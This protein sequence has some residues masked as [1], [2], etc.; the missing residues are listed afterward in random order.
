MVSRPPAGWCRVFERASRIPEA[1]FLY[2]IHRGSNQVP[3]PHTGVTYFLTVREQPVLDTRACAR[4]V[5]EGR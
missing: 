2:F 1:P 4:Q 3:S 5:D